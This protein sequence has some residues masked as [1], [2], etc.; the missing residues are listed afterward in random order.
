MVT[1]KEIEGI[2]KFPAWRKI[3]T[4]KIPT[5]VMKDGLE[6]VE[7][8]EGKIRTFWLKAGSPDRIYGEPASEGVSQIYQAFN[9]QK[10][11]IVQAG[12]T[13]IE[14]LTMGDWET[15]TTLERMLMCQI[16]HPN[17]ISKRVGR[18]GKNFNYVKGRRME[19]EANFAFKYGMSTKIDGWHL[20]IAGVAC[21][22]SISFELDG[23]TVTASDTGIDV[24]EYAKEDKKPIMTICEMM[25]NA[26]TDMIKRCLAQKGFN[27]DVYQGEI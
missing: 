2:L 13:E 5:W 21:Y 3:T 25:K 18:G 20:D 27:R 16:T 1:E 14:P 15:K 17:S 11:G 8:F 6:G 22:G 7:I 24:Q 23:K 26:N 12:T 4:S 10:A 19:D 9:E